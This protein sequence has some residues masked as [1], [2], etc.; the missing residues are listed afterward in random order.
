MNFNL[1]EHQEFMNMVSGSTLQ[2]TIKNYHF[3]DFWYCIKE[4][5]PQLS[6]KVIKCFIHPFPITC[7][8]EAEFSSMKITDHD[9]VTPENDMRF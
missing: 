9:K 4:K 3:F 1:I 6:E 2:L 5:C 8:C 7:L